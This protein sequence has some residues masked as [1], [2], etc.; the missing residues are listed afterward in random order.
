MPLL[1][2]VNPRYTASIEILEHGAGMPALALH[3]AVFDPQALVPSD[4]QQ[5]REASLVGKAILFAQ[6]PLV[7]PA[8]GPWSPVLRVPAPV[9]DLPNFA[10]IPHAGEHIEPRRP[11]LTFFVRADTEASCLDRLKLVAADLDQYLFRR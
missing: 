1:I 11:V 7:F 2:E 6:V 5:S 9:E 10:D 3:R 4:R 8:K